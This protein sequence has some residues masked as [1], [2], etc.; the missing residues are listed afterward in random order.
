MKI[1]KGIVPKLFNISKYNFIIAELFKI[2]K[3]K[4]NFLRDWKISD[5]QH[6]TNLYFFCNGLN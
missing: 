5:N 4:R 6:K 3:N 2:K 1:M